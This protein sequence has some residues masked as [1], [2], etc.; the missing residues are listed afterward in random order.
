MGVYYK[1]VVL[2][3]LIALLV[4]YFLY[5]YFL[6]PRIILY[7]L[8]KKFSKES[9]QWDMHNTKSE[10]LYPLLFQMERMSVISNLKPDDY[11][12]IQMKNTSI[13]SMININKIELNLKNDINMSPIHDSNKLFN[14]IRNSF[15]NDINA[16]YL[17]RSKD[18]IVIKKINKAN[19]YLYL[20]Y[21]STFAKL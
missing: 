7:K 5:Y 16:D 6:F 17:F 19:A 8:K 9:K 1:F 2:I 13:F 12:I 21:I 14:F 4:F 18:L 20:K 11:G 3:I 10:D 15:M